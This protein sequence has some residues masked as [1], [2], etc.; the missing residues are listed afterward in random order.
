MVMIIRNGLVSFFLTL[1]VVGICNATDVLVD[2]DWVNQ[3]LGEPNVVFL[4]VTSNINAYK[5]GHIPGAIFTHYK[6]DKWRVSRKIRGKKGFISQVS[7]KAS[8]L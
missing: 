7:L 2:I 1:T 4:D 8:L 6:K 5:N 3:N